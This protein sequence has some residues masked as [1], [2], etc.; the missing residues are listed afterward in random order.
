MRVS[1]RTKLLDLEYVRVI[2]AVFALFASSQIS[3]PMKPVPIN[4]ASTIVMVLG[5]TLTRKQALESVGS[6]LALGIMGAP[7]FA[8]FSSG[9]AYA[10]GPTGGYLI[11]Y[12][13]ATQVMSFIREK[14]DVQNT[15]TSNIMLVLAGQIA[16]YYCGVTWLSFYLGSVTKAVYAGLV[17]F[18]LPGI[19]KT[20]IL[21]VMINIINPKK[22]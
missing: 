2:L 11:G 8:N 17:P 3:I 19:V 10:L 14:F 9:L 6:F 15:I 4:L 18:I 20:F 16:L 22:R 21:S 12:L 7:V 1:V 5:L 13:A